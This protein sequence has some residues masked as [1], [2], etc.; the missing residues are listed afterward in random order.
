[1]LVCL[2]M[3]SL[4]SWEFFS[5]G[6]EAGCWQGDSSSSGGDGSK[7]MCMCPEYSAY[8]CTAVHFPYNLIYFLYLE[9][10]M[11]QRD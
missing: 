8:T 10:R 9:M 3:I 7:C 4:A 5:V 2:L 11:Q 1:M 6:Y